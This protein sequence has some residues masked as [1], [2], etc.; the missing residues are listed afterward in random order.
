MYDSLIA[1]NLFQF[2]LCVG[3]GDTQAA[4]QATRTV[5]IVTAI[6]DDLTAAEVV[7]P[8][9]GRPQANVTGIAGRFAPST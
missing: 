5:P 7:G 8:N 9:L 1:A 3:I 6:L 2:I 4:A